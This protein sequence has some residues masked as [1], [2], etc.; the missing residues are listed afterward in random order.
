[1]W[2]FEMP[3]NTSLAPTMALLPSDQQIER[4]A[5]A[6]LKPHPRN[7]RRHSRAQVKKLANSMGSLGFVGVV[8]VD[9]ADTIL[10]GHG[11]VEAAKLLDMNE[12]PCLRVTHLTDAQK[13]L[14]L[15]ADNRLGELSHWD[16][17]HLAETL[18]QLGEC[19]ID[20]ELTGFEIA[21][22]DIVIGEHQAKLADADDGFDDPALAQD[23]GPA[24]SRCGDLWQLGVH[25]IVCGSALDGAAYGQ[26]LGDTP[27]QAIVTDPPY[28]VPIGNHVRTGLG[29]VAHREFVQASGEMSPAEFT[30]FLARAFEHMAAHADPGAV[31]FCFMDWRHLQETLAAGEPYFGSLLNL[32]VWDKGTGGMGSLYRSQHELVLVWLVPGER[33]RNNVQLGKHGRNRTNVW[34]YKGLASFGK[35]RDALLGMHPTVK[36]LPMIVD[37][38]KDVTAIGDR[39]LDPFLGSG[40]TILAAEACGRTGYGIELDPLY[41]DLAIRR[42]QG[43]TGR[44][45][46]H[47]ETGLSFEEMAEQRAMEPQP[48]ADAGAAAPITR[49]AAE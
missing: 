34:G 31:I 41:V 2:C 36:P 24:V 43:R 22:V 6:K 18:I 29:A 16:R 47:A 3:M 38:L 28:N 12:V 37:A 7:P 25:R 10:A 8:V 23:P 32:C 14:F 33:H 21:D 46:R 26:L 49:S 1:M 9:E 11:R 30:D 27:V 4:V 15:V 39:V 40:T 5:L 42:W 35:D 17:D 19:D 44:T 20:I 48:D 45:A 13:Q